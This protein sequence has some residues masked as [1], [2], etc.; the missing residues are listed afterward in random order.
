MQITRLEA[1]GLVLIEPRRF[2]DERGV[3]SETYKA[4][5][6]EDAGVRVSF[7]QDNESVTH[8]RG[9]VRGLH[10]QAPSHAQAKLVRVVQGAVLDVAVDLRVGSPT[11]GRATEAELS[12]DNGRQLL[13][14][15]GFAHGFMT[16]SELTIVLYKVSAPY[17][18]AAEGGLLW[19][20]PDL[21]IAWPVPVADA[22]ANA[23][24]AAWPRLAELAPLFTFDGQAL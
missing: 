1:P 19:H 18:P 8:G 7:T 23:R 16:L 3:F 10:F 15:E 9:V 20:D 22:K 17:A 24:D 2:G 4:S 11:Y 14:P 5:A 21:A 13:V 12:A 6:L